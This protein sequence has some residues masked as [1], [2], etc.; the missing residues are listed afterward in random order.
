MSDFN[1]SLP[2]KTELNGDVAV[3]LVD[4]TTVS[5]AL[6]VDAAGLLG[7]KLYDGAGT[8]VTS[9]TSG[10]QQA[11]DVGI[12]VAGVQI[13]PRQ[14]RALTASDVVTANQGAPNTAGNGWF[15]KLTDGTDTASVLATGELTV[16]VTQPLPAGTNLIGS[17]NSRTQDGAGT[18][19]TSTLVNSK[20]RLDVGLASEGVDGSA[21]PFGTLQIGGTDGTNLQSWAMFTSGIGKVGIFDSLGAAF[22]GS[23]PLPVSIASGVSG[24]QVNKYNTSSAVASGASVNHDYTITALK[25][26]SAKKFWASASGKLKAEVQTSPDGTVFTSFWVGFNSTANPVIDIDLGEMKIDTV[27]VGSKVRIIM[28]NKDNQAED[29]YSTISGVEN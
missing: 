27:G 21:V 16:S 4:G 5:Q 15:V 8:A 24:T 12:N 23:N 13:D 10:G 18:A 1:S 14:I 11:L 7:A 28:T 3:K 26:F 6:A 9:Q 2:V 17:V 25:T 20:Q 29:V 22:T 19:I